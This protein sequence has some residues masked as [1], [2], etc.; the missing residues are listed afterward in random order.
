MREFKTVI[1]VRTSIFMYI[2]VYAKT[3]RGNATHVDDIEI[4]K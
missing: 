2:A 1:A 3:T 4:F